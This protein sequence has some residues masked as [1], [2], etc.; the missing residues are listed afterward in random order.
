MVALASLDIAAVVTGL[1]VVVAL[2]IDRFT[3]T[4]YCL[5]YCVAKP[6]RPAVCRATSPFMQAVC[7]NV[8]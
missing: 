6:F 5:C 8:L 7:T 4:R 2:A 1:D 3:F